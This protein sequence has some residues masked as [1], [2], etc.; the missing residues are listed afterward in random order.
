[1]NG[2]TYIGRGGRWRAAKREGR[3]RDSKKK[4]S[5]DEAREVT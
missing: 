2:R 4:T 3:K 1:M 5:L